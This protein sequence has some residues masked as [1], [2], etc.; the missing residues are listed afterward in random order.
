[1]LDFARC[2]DCIS[3]R[4]NKVKLPS[5]SLLNTCH[6]STTAETIPKRKEKRRRWRCWKTVDKAPESQSRLCVA[7]VCDVFF[8]SLLVSVFG[9]TVATLIVAAFSPMCKKKPWLTDRQTYIWLH[10]AGEFEI[11]YLKK[12]DSRLKLKRN[13]LI[14]NAPNM[15][16]V[17]R[18]RLCCQFCA[19]K[20]SV[21]SA[22]SRNCHRGLLPL[23]FVGMSQACEC[24]TFFT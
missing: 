23:P 10:V 5:C 7:F 13:W 20:L 16:E 1:M 17:D 19:A 15:N 18:I 11:L 3:L 12:I 21:G 22:Q 14:W 2:I 6:F 24:F 9:S 4:Y 8:F